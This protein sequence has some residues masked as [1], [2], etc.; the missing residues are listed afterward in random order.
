MIKVPFKWRTN[1][2]G[3][4]MK[5]TPAGDPNLAL[6]KWRLVLA[7]FLVMATVVMH[8]LGHAE[9]MDNSLLTGLGF[10]VVSLAVSWAAC[11]GGAHRV[12]LLS[13]Q[14]LADTIGIGML[15]HFTGGPASVLPLLFCVPIVLA[16]YHLGPRWSVI[17]AGLAAVLT[18]G[19]YF[20]QSMGWLAT[21]QVQ[22]VSEPRGWPFLITAMH[23]ITFIIVGL[24]GGDLARRLAAKDRVQKKNY[25]QVKKAH[26]EVRNILDNIRSGLISVDTRGIISRVNPSCCEILKLNEQQLLGRDINQVMAGGMEDMAVSIVAVAQG[27]DTV[28]RGEV[29]VNCQGRELPLGMNINHVLGL[30]GRILGSIAIFTDLTESKEMTQRMREAD[31]LAAIGELAASIAHEI[32]NPLA[33]LRGSV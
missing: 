27:A 17:I 31:R 6:L 7:S 14:L 5:K 3:V 2:A 10:I 21:G 12:F 24:I 19:G 16:S 13:F 9:S 22:L 8:N 11:M 26:L 30:K 4:T 15:V 29:I 1:M 25:R 28:E 32:K 23:M 20:G 33:S 18:G